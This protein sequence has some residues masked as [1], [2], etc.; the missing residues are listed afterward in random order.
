MGTL[1]DFC[2]HELGR[3]GHLD[4]CLEFWQA[5]AWIFEVW[6][7]EEIECAMF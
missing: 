3:L 7:A 2:E 5:V 1:H 4:F 6:D